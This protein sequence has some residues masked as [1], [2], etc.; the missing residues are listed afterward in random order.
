MKATLL[1]CLFVGLTAL[2]A[3]AS[4]EYPLT[5]IDLQHRLPE[6]IV[7]M[8]E[9]LAGPDGVV[10]GANASLFVRASPARLADI[11]A[12]LARIDVPARN[13][14]LEV[15]RASTRER[16]GQS[17]AVG[18]NERVG[19]HGRVR[20]GGPGRQTGIAAG[21]GQQTISR[22]VLQR[23]RVLD[24]G[25]ALISTGSE[26]PMGYREVLVGPNGAQVRSGVGYA[27]VDTGFYARPRVNGDRVTVDIDSRSGEFG[28]GGRIETSALHTQV[29]GRLGEWLPLGSSRDAGARRG[30]GLLYRQ[31]GSEQS[32]GNLELRVLPA[33]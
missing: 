31:N 15:R 12:A 28:G 16:S 10:T 27:G 14:I 25:Q 22:D 17:V 1:A 33:D 2:A 13:L 21:S 32:I 29:S 23:V 11:R 3:P 18:V 20:I 5:I 19:D 24:G 30:S 6:E 7:P 9:P 8:L 26:Q 4:A